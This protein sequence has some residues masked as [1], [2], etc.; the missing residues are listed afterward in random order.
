[1]TVEEVKVLLEIL[2][3]AYPSAYRNM[4]RESAINT[5][6]LYHN[7]FEGYPSDLVVQALNLYVD[8]NEYPPTVAGIKKY[9]T[10]IQGGDDYEK[11]FSELWMA[12]CGDKRFDEL[13]PQNKRY[14]QSQRALDDLGQSQNT[15]REVVHGQY[16]KRIGDICNEYRAQKRVEEQLGGERLAELQNK[17]KM[18]V[19]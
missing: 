4:S 10:M 14:I 8:E 12:I 2:R 19:G 16:L 1:M 6:K 17:V 13:C 7:R 3:T 11:M 18:I 15:L 9:I 5:V